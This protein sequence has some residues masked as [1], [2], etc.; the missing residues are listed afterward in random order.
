MKDFRLF[1]AVRHIVTVS[2]VSCT[3]KKIHVRTPELT[4]YICYK[5]NKQTKMSELAVDCG[6]ALVLRFSFQETN[7]VTL[8]RLGC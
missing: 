4:L 3:A 5:D 1:E 6:I 8:R 2:T 7:N